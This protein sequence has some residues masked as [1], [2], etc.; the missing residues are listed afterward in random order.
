MDGQRP[1]FSNDTPHMQTRCP[2][3][4]A[5][6]GKCYKKRQRNILKRE[7]L[8]MLDMLGKVPVHLYHA[9]RGIEP[10]YKICN[11]ANSCVLSPWG[12]FSL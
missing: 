3:D 12:I 11:S 1:P 8:L 10:K 5:G 4:V 6:F 7:D 9:V 2:K